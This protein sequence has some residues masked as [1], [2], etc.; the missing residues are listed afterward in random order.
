MGG[1]SEAII[2]FHLN[3]S[4]E[5]IK[6]MVSFDSDLIISIQLKGYVNSFDKNTE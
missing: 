6:K 3:L 5:N 4:L 1:Y 2:I